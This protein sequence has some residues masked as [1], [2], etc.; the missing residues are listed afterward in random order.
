MV[1]FELPVYQSGRGLCH[2]R[3]NSCDCQH[4]LAVFWAQSEWQA[5]WHCGILRKLQDTAMKNCKLHDKLIHTRTIHIGVENH[6]SN[7]VVG[8]G[9]R[10]TQLWIVVS[11]ASIAALCSVLTIYR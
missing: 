4:N 3:T 9:F 10:G 8:W 2:P 7:R 1:Q 6:G 5:I 11:N